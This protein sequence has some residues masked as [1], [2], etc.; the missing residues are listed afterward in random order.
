MN[1][2][3]ILLIPTA[4]VIILFAGVNTAFA[5]RCGNDLIRTGL[6]K[7]EVEIRMALGE[8]GRILSRESY[9]LHRGRPTT[10]GALRRM[11]DAE[12]VR[13]EAAEDGAENFVDWRRKHS[14]CG[15]ERWIVRVRSPYGDEHYCYPLTFRGFTL[16][17]IDIGIK[18]SR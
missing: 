14:D 13:A 18:C 12:R 15:Y 10:F 9:C 5:F 11:Y 6:T 7:A 4:L 2:N 8:C 17:D 16:E 1:R 3:D